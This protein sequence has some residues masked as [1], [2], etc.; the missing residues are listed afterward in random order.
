MA[1][2]DATLWR[3]AYCE[4]GTYGFWDL[5]DGTRVWTC[6]QPW[7][8]NAVGA[9]CIPEGTYR[10]VPGYFNRKSMDVIEITTDGH[11]FIVNGVVRDEILVHPANWPSQLRGCVAP[12]LHLMG[13]D[14]S[15][16][17]EQ[18]GVG[19]T[20]GAA[21]AKIMAAWGGKTFS[22]C[23]AFMDFRKNAGSFTN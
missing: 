8:Q 14:T 7:R 22:L 4:F 9:S 1:T 15:K 13:R 19:A 10:C 5:P 18:F 3:Y 16:P 6:E 20:S 23:V 17:I 11:K 21:F 12:G 2:P